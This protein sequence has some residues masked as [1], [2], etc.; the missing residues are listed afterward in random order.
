MS[1]TAQP[2]TLQLHTAYSVCNSIAR[3]K[4]RNF[5]FGFMVLPAPRRRALSAIYAFMR[6]ADDVADNEALPRPERRRQLREFLDRYH[7]VAEGAATDDPV[8]MAVRDAQRRY[9]IPT[10]LLDKLVSGTAM[11]LEEPEGRAEGLVVAYQNFEELYSYCYHVASVVGLVCIHIFGY[12]GEAAELEAER[13]GI[14]YQLTNI[15]RDIKEDAAM[16][17]V[18]LPQED[19]ARFNVTAAEL[20]EGRELDK[21]RPLLAFEAQRAQEFYQSFDKLLPMVED[22]SQPALWVMTEIYRG[23]LDRIAGNNYDVYTQRARLKGWE[24]ACVLLRGLL[25]RLA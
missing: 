4:A 10:E 16:G 13:L 25:K 21:L 2:T 14:A 9:K 7:S 24:K 8:F 19:L 11:D 1:S 20:A 23:I 15:L 22:Q 6:H 12:N 18:Y 5:Y 3:T 17:R